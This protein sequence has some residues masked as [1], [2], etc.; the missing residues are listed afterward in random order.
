MEVFV[1]KPLGFENS[2]FQNHVFKLTKAIYGLKQARRE[3]YDRLS[4]LF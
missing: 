2:Q 3:L 1:R 4:S